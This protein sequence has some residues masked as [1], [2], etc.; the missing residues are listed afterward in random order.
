MDTT[1]PIVKKIP[2]S[3]D[4]FTLFKQL[5]ELNPTFLIDRIPEYQ[6]LSF[7]GFCRKIELSHIEEIE[8]H[9][10]NI[11]KT[12]DYYNMIIGCIPFEHAY[13]IHQLIEDKKLT[14]YR[15][16]LLIIL[17]KKEHLIEIVDF[18]HKIKISAIIEC[19]KIPNKK[20][21]TIFPGKIPIKSNM[22][23]HE[24]NAM[25]QTSK[26]HIVDGDIF[27]V[28]LS[29]QFL[30]ESSVDGIDLFERSCEYNSSPYQIYIEDNNQ[31]IICT[32]PER[33][34][35][36]KGNQLEV[37]PIAG[38]RARKH[39]GKDD[40][41]GKELLSDPKELSEHLMLVDLGRNDIGRV[42]ETGS[43]VVDKYCQLKNYQHVMHLVST[44]RGQLKNNENKFTAL[45]S[46]FPAGT[47]SGAPKKKSLEI[48]QTL[49]PTRRHLYGG[50]IF[51]STGDYLDSCITIRTILKRNNQLIIQCGSGIV[52]DSIDSK[53]FLETIN[54]GRALLNTLESFYKEGAQYDFDYR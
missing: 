53:E 40:L 32:S 28:V 17:N 12:K 46:V 47:V 35:E 49:E 2:Y 26:K 45:K 25:I 41:R 23:K 33:L 20:K 39:D 6:E 14:V 1:H 7:I 5:S 3:N 4:R 8:E 10:R 9:Q 30:A 43:V 34:L 36:V 37:H 18:N 38:T 27:Q 19:I 15:P 54:K 44:V 51:V 11:P 42:S 52:N 13:Q 29:Q 16:D 24:Y 48:I 50:A 22:T 21:T 31:A